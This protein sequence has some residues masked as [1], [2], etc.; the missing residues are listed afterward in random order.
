MARILM[1]N[2][3]LCDTTPGPRIDVPLFCSCASDHRATQSGTSSRKG[4]EDMDGACRR[5]NAETI[6]APKIVASSAGST[7]LPGPNSR[8][9][10]KTPGDEQPSRNLQSQI[11]RLALGR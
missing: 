1:L 10:D 6:D 11:T 9:D 7:D 4:S 2:P 3:P 5:S 8:L